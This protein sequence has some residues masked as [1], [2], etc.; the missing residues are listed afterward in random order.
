MRSSFV[1][2]HSVHD[3]I[4]APRA[5]ELVESQGRAWTGPYNVAQSKTYFRQGATA[6]ETKAAR[7]LVNKIDAEVHEATHH[8]WAPAP[9]GAYP[10]VPDYLAGDPFSMRTK[11]EERSPA[12]PVRIFL[13]I[14]VAAGVSQQTIARR[15]AA[16]A[17]FAMK[18]SEHRAVELWMC[19]AANNGR[20]RV[21]VGWKC[22]LD[23]PMNVSQIVAAF[24]PAVCRMLNM[25]HWEYQ[26][27][28]K[29]DAN[30]HDTYAFELKG[31]S[32]YRDRDRYVK[33]FRE[34]MELGRDD[35]LLD[36]GILTDVSAIDNDAVKWVKD[37]LA[38]YGEE[39]EG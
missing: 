19:T 31:V 24:S 34:Y 27:T 7:E 28:Q 39:T 16:M 13:A 1:A 8:V 5:V 25:S 9:F 26:V 3:F 22:K 15:G 18:L 11:I 20:W 6:L 12:A 35:I 38:K 21:D 2:Y 23:M 17:A 36:S 37:M 14:G 33:A 30:T 10:I 4:N 32:A 29:T